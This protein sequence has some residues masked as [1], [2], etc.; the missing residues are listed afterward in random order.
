MRATPR[1]TVRVVGLATALVVGLGGCAVS[2]TVG[3][4][5]VTHG[6]ASG[7]VTST[8]VV[9]WSRAS[10]ASRMT[11]EYTPAPGLVWP[12]R[13]QDGPEVAAADDFT[14]KVVL[15][16]LS[17]STAYLY[18]VRFADPRT[19]AETVSETGYFRT[20]PADD[21]TRPVTLLWWGDVGGQG[22]CRDPERGYP[23][24]NQM[25]QV[26]P[27][28]VIAN[29]DS[30]YVDGTCWA[31]GG[32]GDQPDQLW[33]VVSAD[34]ETAAFQQSPATSTAYQSDAEV[35]RAFR[36]KW[37]YNWEDAAFRRLR[38]L[39]AHYFQ[40][41]DHEVINDWYPGDDRVGAIRGTQDTRPVTPLIKAGRKTFLE[42]TPTRPAREGQLYRSV[43][44]GKLAELFVLDTRS[45]RDDNVL[46]DA[47]GTVLNA[48]VASGELRVLR[49][50]AKSIL[51]PAQRDWLLQ[52]LQNAQ[53]R[54]VVWKIIATSDSLSSP[55]GSYELFAPAGAMTPRYTIRDGWAAG[56]RLNADTDGNQGNPTGF[57]SELRTILVAIKSAAI[58]NVVW[59]ASDVHYARLLRY[60]PR[61]ELAGLVFHEF[62]AGP[63]HARSASPRVL[64]TTFGP[65]E[66]FVRG[67]AA[68]P[69]QPSFWNFGVLKITERELIVEIRDIAGSVPSDDQGRAGTLRLAPA[70]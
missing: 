16:G 22:Y 69:T 52:G 63:A 4:P 15:S 20:L 59:V 7:D 27:D 56:M 50:K 45:H 51:G 41:D 66:L 24:F 14:G 46:P 67:R 62:V 10:R 9:I 55:S 28:L 47:P 33:N 21:A 43:R 23:L 61:G 40:W 17:P 34:P 30:V 38:A 68:P 53:R 64:S 31:F 13:R 25:A 18:W 44:L 49:G 36:A 48:R 70:P 58:T 1:L 5:L 12:P 37:K 11:V 57:E 26:A 19:G 39:A 29:G 54:G 35:L 42:Y 60:E 3:P 65:Q 8:D 2:L 6:V 32:F